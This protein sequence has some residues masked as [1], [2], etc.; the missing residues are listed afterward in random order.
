[1][2][3][4]ED[5]TPPAKEGAEE[6]P[7][8]A[9]SVEPTAETASSDVAAPSPET[10]PELAYPTIETLRREATE[11][12]HDTPPSL[13]TFAH[14]LV[15]WMRAALAEDSTAETVA[16]TVDALAR[17]AEPP[18]GT[19][20]VVRPVRMLC[21]MNLQRLRKAKADRYP[22]AAARIDSVIRTAPPEL[23]KRLQIAEKLGDSSVAP[24]ASHHEGSEGAE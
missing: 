4:V 22:E 17:C 18:R 12:P 6:T 9:S 16:R 23:I 21:L 10:L 15:P 20:D 13:R 14:G 19:P 2:S 8:D 5:S 24:E 11:N 7:G 1:M 3:A